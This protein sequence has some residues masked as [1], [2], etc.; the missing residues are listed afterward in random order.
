MS[1]GTGIAL[2]PGVC[3]L[4]TER[5]LAQAEAVFPGIE[6]LYEELVEKPGTFLQLLWVYARLHPC[7][8]DELPSGEDRQFGDGSAPDL[9]EK[10][11][12]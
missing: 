2:K 9:S 6:R 11:R 10:S 5:D 4:I 12:S 7:M 3:G 8:G 1:F